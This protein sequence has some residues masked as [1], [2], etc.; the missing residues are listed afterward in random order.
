MEKIKSKSQ[1][2][3]IAIQKGESLKEFVRC[4]RCDEVLP[5][6]EMVQVKIIGLISPRYIC[7]KCYRGEKGELFDKNKPKSDPGTDGKEGNRK[8]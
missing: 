3:R 5:L 7:G 1:A 2:K 6:E 8:D 4:Y